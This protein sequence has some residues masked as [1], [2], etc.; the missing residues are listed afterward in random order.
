MSWARLE[1]GMFE[2]YKKKT[3]KQNVSKTNNAPVGHIHIV[4]AYAMSRIRR[5]AN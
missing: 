1:S 4:Y 3:H 2:K 5:S